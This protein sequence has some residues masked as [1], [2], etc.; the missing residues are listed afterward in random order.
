[1]TFALLPLAGLNL[2]RRNRQRTLLTVLAVMAVTVVFSAVMVIPYAMTAI[3]DHA[4]AVPRLPVTN[5]A[6]VRRGLPE[7]Y[8][9]KI[10]KEFHDNRT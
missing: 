6:E 10:E 2:W 9:V 5:R 8:Y 1:M 7:S 3:V 4:D